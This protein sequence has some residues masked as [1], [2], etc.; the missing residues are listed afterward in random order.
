MNE[1][2]NDSKEFTRKRTMKNPQV[3]QEIECR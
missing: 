2:M 1:Q 3:V